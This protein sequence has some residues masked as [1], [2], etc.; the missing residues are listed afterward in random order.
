LYP[1]LYRD[2]RTAST[3]FRRMADI[4]VVLTGDVDQTSITRLMHE[5]TD[6]V[7][8]G[9][10]SLLLAMSTPGGQVYWGVTAYGFL[11]GLGIDVITHNIGQVDSIGGPIY[12]SGDHRLSISQGRFLIHSIY[13]GFGAGTSLSEK[14]LAD[15]LDSVVRDRERVATIL[16]ERTGT[17]LTTVTDNMRD[18]RILDAAEGQAYGFVHEIADDVFDPAQEIVTIGP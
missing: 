10:R 18:T 11:R 5:V 7:G 12:L 6:R 16:S 2:G 3:S 15:T 17:D 8:K 13:W 1:S 9:A 14:Q 4:Q